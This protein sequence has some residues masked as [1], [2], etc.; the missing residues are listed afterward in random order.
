L[1]AQVITT[2]SRI[3][4]AKWVADVLQAQKSE[5]DQLA[6]FLG[7]DSVSAARS[8]WHRKHYELTARLITEIRESRKMRKTELEQLRSSFR[9]V[10]AE[11]VLRHRTVVGAG[12]LSAFA[13]AISVHAVRY[14]AKLDGLAAQGV[15]IA[16]IAATSAE[17]KQFADAAVRAAFERGAVELEPAG[18]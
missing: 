5:L 17:I 15:G 6:D 2:Y 1:V 12:N 8:A 11:E 10:V 7:E 9:A 4:G 3:D 13:G 14:Q 16:A 18:D